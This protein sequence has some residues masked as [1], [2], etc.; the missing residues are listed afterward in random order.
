MKLELDELLED[1]EVAIIFNQMG[2]VFHLF[3]E[4]YDGENSY[5]FVFR[6]EQV[7]EVLKE[8]RSKAAD[9]R[10]EYKEFTPY[11]AAIAS[12]FLREY[13]SIRS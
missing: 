8:M 7:D 5:G 1:E 13:F 11:T 3:L 9:K 12:M 4:N 2:N 6:R 10:A